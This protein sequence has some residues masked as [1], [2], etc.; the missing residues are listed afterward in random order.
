[1]AIFDTGLLLAF[2]I[3]LLLSS[4]TSLE[5]CEQTYYVEI[6]TR[7]L[8]PCSCNGSSL[9][10]IAWVNVN[11][12]KTLLLLY[13]DDK[14]GD[15]YESGEYDIYPNG[16]LLINNVTASHESVYRVSTAISTL[17]DRFS[18]NICVHTTV[19]PAITIPV[20]EECSNT[21]GTTCVK[22]TTDSV[23]V[24][25]FVRDSR[26]AVKLSWSLRTHGGDHILPSN[27]KKYTFDDVT[28]TSHVTATLS[29]GESS[30]LSLLAC[31]ANNVPLN[32]V[33]D[34]NVLLIEKEMDYTSLVTP[35]RRYLKIHSPMNLSC[36]DLGLNLVIWKWSPESDAFETLYVSI[37]QNS[38]HTKISNMEYKLEHE[39][40]LSLQNT[41]VEHE[42]L[43]ACV[44]DNGVSGGIVLYDVLVMVDPTPS[45][46][47]IDGC[48]HQQYCVLEKQ[49]QDVLTCSVL[50][51]RPKVA[52]EWRAF[53]EE[54]A[55][56]FTQHQFTVTQ[57]GDLYDIS[58]T[59][60]FDF[61]LT[62]QNK[63]TV[64]CGAVG[65]NAELFS[66]STK[67]D[68]LFP[69]VLP[70]EQ[71]SYTFT[72]TIIA[73]LV[74][75]MM[76]IITAAVVII[77]RIR[78]RKMKRIK[79]GDTENEGI[80]MMEN[81]NGKAERFIEH[82]KAKYEI[83]Y[84]SV[85]PIPYIKDRMYCVD[86]VFVEG[87][88]EYMTGIS[89]GQ[90]QWDKLSSYQ[91]L[92]KENCLKTKR[93]ILEGEPGYGKSTLTLQ[94]L[95]DWC[96]S[97]SK[98]S[99][100]GVDVI[101]YLR[102][103]QLRGVE[104][105]FSAIRQFILPRD[106]DISEEDI[107]EILNHMSSVLVLLDGFDEYPDQESTETDIYHIMKKDM[108]QGFNVILT[109]RPSCVPTDFAPHSDRVR[110]TGFGEEARKKYVEK[111]VVGKCGEAVNELL[112]KLE[113]NPVLDDL[114]QV[115]LFFVTFAHM[116]YEGEHSLT[117]SS[118]TSFFRYMISC[119][120]SHMKNKMRDRNVTNFALLEK[121]HKVLDK[122]AFEAMS[123]KNQKLVW[124]REQLRNELGHEFYDLYLRI[125]IFVEEEVL[126]IADTL[127]AQYDIQYNTEVHFYHKIFCEWYAAHYIAEQLSGGNTDCIDEF[128]QNLDPFDLQYLYRFA[129]GINK[130]A[131]EKII[132]YLQQKKESTKFAILCML[133][134]EDKT[135]RFIK[136][137][138]DL[139]SSQ[140][141]YIM[142][143][144]SKLLQRSTLQLLDVASKNHIPIS[145]LN[146]QWSFSGFDGKDIRLESGLSLSSLSSVE[147]ISINAGGLEQE[148]TEEEVIGLIKYGIK[149]S[150]FKELWL[151]NCKLPS[152]IKPDI[153]PEE[154]RSR[155]V[156]V[157]SS[158]EAR[159]LDLISGQWRKPDDIQTITE[160]CSDA[161]AIHRDTS[162]SVKRSV[163]ELLVE[164]SN[165]DIPIYCVHLVWSFSKID[166]D[167]NIILS[168]GLS[169]PIITSMERMSIQTE[170]GREMN[171]HEV[172]GI[173]NYL[174]HSQRFKEL[175]LDGCLLPS[176]IPV[177]PTLSTLK[178]R[179][180]N[181]FWTPNAHKSDEYYRLDLDS[182]R[183]RKV[184]SW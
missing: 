107:K 21:Y 62:T 39:G 117:F 128:L 25:C 94:L 181:V 9:A 152:S 164:A 61:T 26:P 157:I 167:G 89:G 149:S 144:D 148:F 27:Y 177:G 24:N 70:T 116:T 48:N 104:S 90:A 42:G 160:M 46:P 111:A 115:P 176:S 106:S 137:V 23:E 159:Y 80:P 34:E 182:G 158:K 109:T 54:T 49:L 92:V 35:I 3:I 180:V 140:V 59:V 156:K 146:L 85:Q 79:P 108:F 5:E 65:E 127:N 114:C 75:M 76:M 19:K 136:S 36:T 6:G 161:L 153:I 14:R 126:N 11:E 183:W 37:F 121:E 98:T 56:D 120:H 124:N 184:G 83:F 165:H 171:K 10:L 32:L 100:R 173:L 82:L 174:Q 166:E 74:T 105:I 78:A 8:I 133:E 88:I 103:R 50:G 141:T 110:L 102:L 150:S 28:Y 139:V 81:T 1:M 68:L 143:E 96:K 31:R 57:M 33:E 66:L 86:K 16:S 172:N 58:L 99:S 13:D 132:R 69:N 47:V 30:V 101:T 118:V 72:I 122:I 77:C 179:G 119:F 22:S 154:S 125:G 135:D 2:A 97:H 113:E 4:A 53:R 17:H 142:R 170:K 169:L 95:Y 131:G 73:V 52:L 112:R 44:Y 60:N 130:I 71:R 64:E 123:G 168:S 41:L 155:N 40:S 178:S 15:G 147:K 91:E 18:K 67:V 145:D 151:N 20:I 43:Y 87:G 55:I 12:G 163:I 134:Q 7:G 29:F 45:F 93:Q 129:C 63:V 84:D 38:N 138:S 162:E 51:I 175:Q